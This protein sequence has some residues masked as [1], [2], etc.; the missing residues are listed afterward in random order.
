MSQ[1]GYIVASIDNRGT[2]SLRG[3]DFRKALYGGIGILSS[4]DQADSQKAMHER[5][6]FIDPDRVGIWG[7]SGGGS[8]TLNMLFRYPEL[9]KVGVSRAPV[10]DQ[11]LYD[12]IYQ[13]RYSGLLDQYS[14]GYE[15]GS[16][17]CATTGNSIFLLTRI[18]HTAFAS[19]RARSCI[20]TRR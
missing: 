9:Y 16:P 17:W 19:G 12:A 4:H 1:K 7:H 5:W 3:R 13:E 14:E 10:P 18:A 20:C 2:P 8:M 15:Q 6:E 11:R